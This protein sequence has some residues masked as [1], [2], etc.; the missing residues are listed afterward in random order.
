MLAGF[1]CR[2]RSD[3]PTALPARPDYSLSVIDVVG[4]TARGWMDLPEPE[5]DIVRAAWDQAYFRLVGVEDP[6]AVANARQSALSFIAGHRVEELESLGREIFDEAMSRRIWPGTRALAQMHLDQGQRVW[7]VTA[8][9]VEIA[10]IIVE[11]TLGKQFAYQIVPEFGG[12]SPAIVDANFTW[13][14]SPELGFKFGRFKGPVGLELLQSD[15][16]TFFNE[17]TVVSAL[18]PN[19]DLGIVAQ[20]DLFDKKL[21]YTVGLIGGV[22]DGANTTKKKVPQK[23]A[24]FP[25]H[26]S[27][28]L[29]N[30][31]GA[32]S[33]AG[34]STSENFV[35]SSGP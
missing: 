9:P 3:H 28:R 24:A 31:T 18:V 11:G 19:R 14:L 2:C 5:R 7:L 10:R 8:A 35:T 6:D 34:N 25:R 13:T 4:V 26:A 29:I 21:N 16:W 32:S 27:H 22:A 1:L 30:P 33:K 20:G 23:P 17:R 15:A 12:S